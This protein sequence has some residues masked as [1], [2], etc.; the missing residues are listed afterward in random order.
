MRLEGERGNEEDPQNSEEATRR[1]L[2]L[3]AQGAQTSDQAFD[4]IW[5]RGC[6]RGVPVDRR[7]AALFH[8]RA[9]ACPKSLIR[10]S[11]SSIPTETL[12]RVSL[13]PIFALSSAESCV[14]V[15]VAGCATRVSTP[16]R[17]AARVATLTDSVN[18]IASFIEPRISKLSIPPNPFICL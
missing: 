12:T 1:A 9:R 17:L 8:I 11:T 18:F 5:E 2:S 4:S 10:S 15:R 16:P 7:V 14:W 3:L 6:R 13:M